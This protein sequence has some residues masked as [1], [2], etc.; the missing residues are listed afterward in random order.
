VS[1]KVGEVE[2]GKHM[3]LEETC[4]QSLEKESSMEEEVDKHIHVGV[5][6]F[7]IQPWVMV[8]NMGVVESYRH[9]VVVEICMYV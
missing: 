1:N 5:V 4:T 7:C 2:N 9:M 3:V 6:E 8:N